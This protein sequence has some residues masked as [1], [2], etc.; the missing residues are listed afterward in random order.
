[1]KF[2]VESK[3][4]LKLRRTRIKPKLFS[5]I[6]TFAITSFVK[7]NLERKRDSGSEFFNIYDEVCTGNQFSKSL[8]LVQ[9]F[10]LKRHQ[11]LE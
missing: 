11:A 1:M 3:S 7:L 6:L 9:L 2:L 4:D 8:K 5:F 10:N